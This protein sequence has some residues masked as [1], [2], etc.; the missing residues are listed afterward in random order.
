MV[1]KPGI[2]LLAVGLMMSMACLGMR[3][4]DVGRQTTREMEYRASLLD[5]CLVYAIPTGTVVYE[6]DPAD[7]HRLVSEQG[8]IQLSDYAAGMPCHPWQDLMSQ[9]RPTAAVADK[10]PGGTV[11]LHERF[12]PSGRRVLVHAR[13][14]P[15]PFF[16]GRGELEVSV[17]AVDSTAQAPVPLGRHV[18]DDFW[19]FHMWARPVRQVLPHPDVHTLRLYSGQ[20]DPRDA[21]RFGFDYEIDGA[22][23]RMTV[24][25][26]DPD[27]EAEMPEWPVIKIVGSVA[28][29]GSEIAP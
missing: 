24:T 16:E 2:V 6:E 1:T 28:G 12:T 21:G 22:R 18:Y 7:A 10:H 19:L 27:P 3:R 20:A 4:D 29:S 17:L 13:Y 23:Q 15:S 11:F 5:K 26:L 25:I 9:I 14:R 8:Y